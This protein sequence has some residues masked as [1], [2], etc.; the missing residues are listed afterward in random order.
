MSGD[1]FPPPPP[2]LPQFRPDKSIRS[3]T[4]GTYERINMKRD[5]PLPLSGRFVYTNVEEPT[6]SAV[7]EIRRMCRIII[8]RYAGEASRNNGI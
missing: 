4:A 7:E 3:I 6:F 1:S 5:Q 2:P 8:D